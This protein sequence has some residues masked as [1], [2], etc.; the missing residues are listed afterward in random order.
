MRK[1]LSTYSQAQNGEQMSEKLGA[2]CSD[3]LHPDVYFDPNA[4]VLI[5]LKRV[6]ELEAELKHYREN[7]QKIDDQKERMQFLEDRHKEDLKQI[8][9]L[10]ATIKELK[11]GHGNSQ[12]PKK[13]S[14]NSDIPPSK[15][16][17]ASAEKRKRTRSL[18][19]PSGKKTGGQSGHKGYTLSKK[20]EVDET[21]DMSLDVCP[22]CAADLSAVPVA[23]RLS[24]QV[25]DIRIQQPK[26]VLYSILEKICPSCGKTV[27]SKFPENVKGAV[28]YGPTVQALIVYLAE[29]HAVSYERIKRFL[30]DLF[31][32]D[33][34]QG[35]IDNIIKKMT[36]QTRGLY[37][38]IKEKVGRSSVVGAD[39]TGI[40]INGVMHW[41]WV[42]QTESASY[43][44]PHKKR[45]FDAI[46]ETFPDGLPNATLVTDRHGS[47]FKMQVKNRQI[48]LVH[49]LRNLAFLIE[50]MPKARWSKDMLQLINDAIKEPYEKPWEEIDRDGLKKRLDELL[51]APLGTDDKDFVRMRNGLAN[52]KD[53][54][55]TFLDNQNVPFDNNASERAIR[56]TK[57]KLKVAGLFRS[58]DGAESYAIIHSILDTTKKQGV[59]LFDELQAI[60]QRKPSLLSL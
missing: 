49:L 48:C 54:I 26:V 3:G 56:P 8:K 53:C 44:V 47:Y 59:S 18:R 29:E 60:A 41:L 11:K 35:T 37:D 43:F 4:M 50:K 24:R 40:D 1:G 46:Q 9:E 28:S 33:L 22:N 25:I 51:E 6:G 30:H 7:N 45:S 27:R 13:D 57:T 55:L 21:I 15:E 39:E 42:W 19:Q 17:I 23:Q 14:H 36:E 34:S 52:K 32:I 5:L 16:D 20:E 31:R 10:K 38:R 12:T 2:F 58:N